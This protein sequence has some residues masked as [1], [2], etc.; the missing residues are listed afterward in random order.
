MGREVYYGLYRLP[1]V[2]LNGKLKKNK[3]THA[4]DGNLKHEP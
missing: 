4:L 3:Q 1:P 2:S